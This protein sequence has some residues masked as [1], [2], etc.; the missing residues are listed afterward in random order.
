[1]AST[2]TYTFFWL[3]D[4]R[5]SQNS[6]RITE[7]RMHIQKYLPTTT[8][9]LLSITSCLFQIL[10]FFPG[11]GASELFHRRLPLFP[12]AAGCWSPVPVTNPT[13]MPPGGSPNHNTNK[14]TSWACRTM[15]MEK[16]TG[17]QL[18]NER[19]K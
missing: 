15:L 8:R 13:R 2:D 6:Q 7:G 18:M 14:T 3:T 16:S 1:M 17:N 4:C 10:P 19:D 9:G 5:I 12:S 11:R